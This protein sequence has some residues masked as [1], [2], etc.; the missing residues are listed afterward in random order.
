MVRAEASIIIDRP[1]ED[2]FDFVAVRFFD[3]YPR[4][5]PEVIDLIATTPPPVR[6]GTAAR[7]VRIDQ[8]RRSE[9]TFRVSAFE[10]ANRIVFQGISNPFLIVY[11]FDPLGDKDKTR[12]TFT[13]ELSR[14]E[15]FMR[16]FEKLIHVTVQDGAE[17]VVHNIRGLIEVER[18]ADKP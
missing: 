10:T 17:R 9:S 18:S 16:P 4:W 11:R 1:V 3:N 8:G 6:A 13:F 7:Q 5:S 2:V 12:L 15:F 14:L